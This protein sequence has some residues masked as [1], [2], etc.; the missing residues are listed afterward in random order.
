MRRTLLAPCLAGLSLAVAV[1]VASSA[2]AVPSPQEV[3]PGSVVRWPGEGISRCAMA[4]KSWA[5][6]AG[7]CY[8]AVDLLAEGTFT[9]ERTQAGKTER[10]TLRVAAYPYPEQHI[11]IQ[12]QSKVDLSPADLKRTEREE[13]EVGKLF[14]SS[15]S[16]RFT[17]PLGRP[18][19]ELPPG[20]RFGS[21]R[22]FNGQPRNPHTGADFAATE[23][24][25][26]FASAEGKVVLAK[27]LFFSGNSVFVDHGDGLITMYFHF[28]KILVKVGQEV[29]RGS[30][31]GLVGATGRASGPHLHMGVRWHGARVDPEPLLAAPGT[32]PALN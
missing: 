28:S 5:P 10:R 16:R 6:L 29:K 19:T 31:V 21:R 11:E 22:W 1:R 18:L 9:V 4:S 32:I 24:T 13:R 17:L 23:G 27:D 8:F 15:G 12:D 26:V 20:G 30:E 3:K 2:V 25:P 7:A 14:A